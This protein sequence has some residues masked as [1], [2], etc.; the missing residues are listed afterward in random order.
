[1]CRVLFAFALASLAAATRADEPKPSPVP[2][3]TP[4]PLV[5]PF[6]GGELGHVGRIE[7][8]PD[9]SRVG[10][11]LGYQYLDGID[12]LRVTPALDLRSEK[13]QLGLAAPLRLE[14]C[15]GS[16]PMENC[17]QSGSIKLAP[18]DHRWRLRNRDYAELADYAKVIRYF[19]VGKVGDAFRLDVTQLDPTTLGHGGLMRG[20]F[21]SGN[22][23]LPRVSAEVDLQASF[24]GV[25]AF[26]NDVAR[27]DILAGRAFASPLELVSS[28]ALARAFTVG[29]TWVSDRH[30]PTGARAGQSLIGA[31]TPA[32]GYDQRAVTGMGADAEV[33]LV[34]TAIWEVRPYAALD[35]LQGAGSGTSAGVLAQASLFTGSKMAQKLRLVAEA[36]SFDADYLPGYF[37]TFY[38]VEKYQYGASANGTPPTKWQAVSTRTGPRRQGAYLE[39]TYTL[40]QALVLAGGLEYAN[41]PWTRNVYLHAELAAGQFLRLFGTLYRRGFEGQ[42]W[43][44]RSVLDL[45][46]TAFFA[47]AR[48]ELL[49]F[50]FANGG[51]TQTVRFDNATGQLENARKFTANLELGLEF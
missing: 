38:E 7:I 6:P 8:V 31:E 4:S 40:G 13:Y 28:G 50:L 42:P 11:Q 30:A 10:V 26:A 44:T 51:V 9:G 41:Q 24:G 46:N 45:P 18:Y 19:T 12:Y 39:A 27:P 49:P 20:Y 21:P 35:R 34:K 2:S 29:A 33:Q 14:L 15:A 16:K 1:M 17:F 36:R 48:L 32:A 47:G 23:D 25:T 37:D 3:P 43:F 22:L 5:A